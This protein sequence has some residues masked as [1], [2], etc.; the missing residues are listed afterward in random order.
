MQKHL[1]GSGMIP[2]HCN[3]YLPD[4]SDSPSSASQV[5]GIIGVHHHVWLIFVFL[6]ETGF[7]HVGQAGFELLTWDDLPTLAS[8]S[9]GIY[10]HKPLHPADTMIFYLENPHSFCSKPPRSDKQLQQSFRIQNQYAIVSSISMHHNIQPENQIKNTIL[11]Q[12]QNK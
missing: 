3:L 1:S 4:S 6:A 7:H 11:Q 12:P 10:R 5:A 9:A 2:A 8:Q